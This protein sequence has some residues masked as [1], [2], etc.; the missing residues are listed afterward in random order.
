[1]VLLPQFSPTT[2]QTPK[3]RVKGRDSTFVRHIRGVQNECGKDHEK[4]NYE[5]LL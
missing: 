3:H 2:F 1:M 5:L 4:T